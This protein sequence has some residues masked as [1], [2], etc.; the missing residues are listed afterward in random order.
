VTKIVSELNA[1]IYDEDGWKNH[2]EKIILPSWGD[3]D[4]AIQNMHHFSR[5][6]V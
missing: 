3:I 5:A 2:T 4:T 6:S 1:V